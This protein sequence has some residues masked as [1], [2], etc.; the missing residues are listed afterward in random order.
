MTNRNQP[1]PPAPVVDMPYSVNAEGSVL[2]SLM[3]NNDC[4]DDVSLIVKASDFW[5]APH[6]F[7]FEAMAALIARGRPIDLITLSEELER[8]GSI[9]RV[10]G[11]AGLAEMSKYTP[12]AANV[13]HYAE[14]VAEKSRLRALL[15]TAG[16]IITDVQS[17][18]GTSAQILDAAESRLFTLAEQRQEGAEDYELLSILERTVARI[19]NS[20]S[21]DG[22]TGTPTG[23]SELD[24]MT[25]GPQDGDLILLAAR[26]SMGKTALATAICTGA[27]RNTSKPTFI[28]SIEMEPEQLC[29]RQ[30]SALGRVPLNTLR[31]GQLNDEDWARV[32]DAMAQMTEW[33]DRLIIDGSSLMTPS[34]L[35]ARARRYVRQYGKPALIMVDYL[36][37]MRCPGEENRTQE[38][39]QISRSLKAL[40]K[41]LSCPVLA[42]SQLNR[43]VES[44]ADK[45][46]N[47]GDLRDSGALEQDADLIMML[48]RDE[49]YNASSPDAGTAEIIITKQRQG[50][51]GT[52]KVRFD[53]RF[54]LFD[55]FP[56]G[57][58]DL[59]YGGYRA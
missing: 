26:P 20:M 18:G 47:N 39:A 4:W 41:E 43:S 46:P 59:G 48:Y 5:L 57:H 29:L 30:I 58:H 8:Q 42:L 15:Q 55:D 56:E 13:T 32:S 35:R 23:F 25:C 6:R 24:L 40:A 45:R 33:K 38:I 19:E 31:S 12:S 51:T 2:G 34:I 9:D 14:V 52:V 11:F 3:L 27:L 21:S 22:V 36:Q 50:Q 54:T 53:G 7:T 10:G 28:F 1:S 49:V 17:P 37:L 44:R 16:T